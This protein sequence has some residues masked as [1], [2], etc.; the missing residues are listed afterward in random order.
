MEQNTNDEEQFLLNET[1]N[2]LEFPVIL[3]F[4]SNYCFSEP[5]K[6]VISSL[7]PLEDYFYLKLEHILIEEMTALLSLDEHVPFEGFS[8]IR[9]KLYKSLVKNAVLLPEEILSLN[10]SIRASRLIKSFFV[11]RKDTY[12]NLNEEASNLHDN[13]LLEKHIEDTINETGEVRDNATK[14]L[15]RIR[16]EIL[17]KSG[18]LRHRLNSIL[19]KVSGDD[20][21]QEEF[22]SLREG[23]F[24][25][26]VKVEH[27]RHIQGI[28]HGL[29][30][31]G[32]TVFM[33]PA[34][35]IE[36]NNELS[37]L[38]S[39]E[40]REIY[41]ILTN[42]T[43]EIGDEAQSFLG[44]MDIIAHLDSLYA[45]AKYAMEFGGLKPDIID[46]NEIQLT[47][48]KHPLLVHSK[49]KNKVVQM[50]IEF[51]DEKRGHL[52]SGPNAGGKT[53]A[54]K[55]V[56]LNIAMALSGIFPLGMCRTNFRNIFS[57]IGDHQS[58]QNDLSTFSSQIIRLKN[59]LEYSTK[60]SLVL[61]DEIGSGT[62][63]QEGT[64]LASG[65]LDS[66]LE[67]KSF[68]VATTHH[69]S[70]KTYALTRS[71]IE[72]DSLEFNESQ[73]KPTYKFLQGVPGNSY[74]FQLAENLGLSSLV[75]DRA[76]KYIGTKH[77]ELEE[78]ISMLQ[79]YKSE[80]EELRM[81]AEQEKVLTEKIRKDYEIKYKDI[82]QK[83]QNLIDNAYKDA[84]DILANANA[85]IENT[86]REIREGEK[87]IAGIKSRFHAEKANIEAKIKESVSDDIS[88]PEVREFKIGDHVTSEDSI[89]TG[90]I[91][92]L[93]P[94]NGT[95]LCDFNG[96]KFK[97]P[98]AGLILVKKQ[99]K[100]KKGTSIANNIK[101]DVQTTLDLRGKR[102]GEALNETDE[103]IS[104]ALMANVA[105]ITI[106]HGK[107]TGALRKAIH[108]FLAMHPS[109]L[110]FREGTLPEGGAGVTVVELL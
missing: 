90:V 86:I 51:A 22:I 6:E 91:L 61:I 15:A 92:E 88:K 109:K 74:A 17:E 60:D 33:E 55:S 75:L 78:S 82:K 99:K 14:E 72:N 54:L 36:M 63:P 95:A 80:A 5:G 4:L 9:P 18:R 29:S 23:R 12:P 25:L 110:T 81:E 79:K 19:K 2:Q 70:L 26:P 85:L 3:N 98:L 57:S 37:L 83:R 24:V 41:K 102:A 27:K 10:A 64:A 53:V 44:S 77:S 31:T 34:E 105:F 94:E 96:V 69:S 32:S 100:A 39:E 59:I 104:N 35:V 7:K 8:D 13:R 62:D 67:L 43:A 87:S 93:Y 20:L 107:G 101:F 76:K 16:K 108:E 56:G 46:E 84:N 50:S 42:L 49:G 66:F 40:K 28:I 89:I 11:S 45:R 21:L 65:I 106:I 48:I 52:I 103:F 97:L 38:L 47:Y 68:F 30:Q 73:L 71:E 1:L 58:I